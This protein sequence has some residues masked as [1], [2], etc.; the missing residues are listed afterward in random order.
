MHA[1]QHDYQLIALISRKYLISPHRMNDEE[2]EDGEEWEGFSEQDEE[3]PESAYAADSVFGI[4][5]RQP[6]MDELMMVR[7]CWM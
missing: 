3:E 2:E 1:V 4:A 7:D 5:G 6:S